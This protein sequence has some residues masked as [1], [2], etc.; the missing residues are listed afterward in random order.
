[1]FKHGVI[2]ILALKAGNRKRFL[3]NEGKAVKQSNSEAFSPQIIS[4]TDILV[5][6]ARALNQIY[7]TEPVKIDR[8]STSYIFANIFCS[9]RSISIW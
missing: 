3:G 5:I 9:K 8:V 6:E 2:L 4:T 7:V 1:M